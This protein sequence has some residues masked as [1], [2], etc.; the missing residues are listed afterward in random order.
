M[1]DVERVV[2][3]LASPPVAAVPVSDLVPIETGKLRREHG[4]QIRIRKAADAGEAR[5]QRDVDEVVET[6]EDAARGE[7]ADAGK[8][9]EV[10]VRVAVLDDSVETTE[11]VA[12]GGARLWR[13]QQVQ[14]RLVVVVYQHHDALA[15]ALV[16]LPDQTAEAYR[17]GGGTGSDPRALLQRIQL[18]RHMRRDVVFPS[19]P[20]AAEAQTQH[21]MTNRPV[22]ATMD[23]QPPE[24]RLVAFEQLLEGVQQQ[25]LAEAPR[26]RENVVLG[27]VDQPRDVGGLVDA[28][29]VPFPDLPERLDAD[30]QSASGHRPLCPALRGPTESLRDA[31]VFAS[32]SPID[33]ALVKFMNLPTEIRRARRNSK[34]PSASQVARLTSPV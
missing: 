14:H 13:V 23:G 34:I 2:D 21:R 6:G 28:V 22:P 20:A 5:I 26:A 12:D 30:R 15:A 11:E 27:L 10:H 3:H 19:K 8:K 24:Q 16:Q 31:R 32:G 9:R 4:I 25:A 18:V 1:E 33:S 17:R 7:P 29:V